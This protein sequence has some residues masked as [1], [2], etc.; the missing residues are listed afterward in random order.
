[1]N[2]TRRK[3][4]KGII[5]KLEELESLK[6]EIQEELQGVLDEEQEAFD[7]LPES[8]QDSDRGEQMQECIDTL[9]QI[10][11]DLDQLDTEDMISNLGEL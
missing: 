10:C 4:I 11:D 1:M 7:N 6:A 2:N 5:T 3:T 9:Q 8:L